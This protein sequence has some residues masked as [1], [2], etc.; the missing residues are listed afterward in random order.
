MYLFIFEDLT[1]RKSLT[2]TEEDAASCDEGILDVIDL[3]AENPKQYYDGEWNDVENYPD[4][5]RNMN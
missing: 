1:I 3:H 2:F 5:H 4:E